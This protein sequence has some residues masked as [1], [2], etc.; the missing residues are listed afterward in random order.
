M[1]GI[2]VVVMRSV[3]GQIHQGMG[4]SV[5]HHKLWRNYEYNSIRGDIEIL[6]NTEGVFSTAYRIHSEEN[7]KLDLIDDMEAEMQRRALANK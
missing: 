4:S 2:D 3:C 1:A 6:R 7:C 5:F